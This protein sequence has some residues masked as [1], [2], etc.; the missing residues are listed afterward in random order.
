MRTRL[1]AA[2]VG[3]AAVGGAF[4]DG[5]GS[6]DDLLTWGIAYADFLLVGCLLGWLLARLTPQ[7]QP[8]EFVWKWFD[9]FRAPTERERDGDV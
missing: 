2:V 4:L 1:W 6:L 3:V 8:P 5:G 9:F 7:W